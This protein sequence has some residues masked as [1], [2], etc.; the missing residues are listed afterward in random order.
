VN[1]DLARESG[2]APTARA[3]LEVTTTESKPCTVESSLALLNRAW[4]R[5]RIELVSPDRQLSPWRPRGPWQHARTGDGAVRRTGRGGHV[6]G[7]AGRVISC[8]PIFGFARCGGMAGTRDQAGGREGPRR[9]GRRRR[10]FL[11]IGRFLRFPLS[12]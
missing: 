8:S 2:L 3:E 4:R 9:L 10:R 1:Q 7:S 6:S 12:P 11:F 5:R